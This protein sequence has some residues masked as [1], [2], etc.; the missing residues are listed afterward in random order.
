VPIQ[1][2]EVVPWG[3]SF[4][5]YR[6]MFALSPEDLAGRILGCGD[7]PASFNVEATAAGHAVVSC[8]P[9]YDFSPAEIEKRVFD[10]C[11][12]MVVQVRRDR[13]GFVWQEFRDPEHLG[14]CRL[15]VMR[16]FLANFEQGKR[17]GRYV[18]AALPNL[19]FGADRFD[20]ALVSHLLFLYSEQLDF[21][22]HWSGIQEL[23][24][25]A[26]EVRIFPLLTLERKKSPH[27]EPV[28]ARCRESGWTAEA[29]RVPYEFQRGGNEMLRIRRCANAAPR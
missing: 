23:L 28:L 11:Q 5:E 24:R 19:P 1:L 14:E 29:C 22:F 26:T 8:D 3:R 17:A 10:C 12:D 4:D 6:R 7:G 13:A 15:A 25:V 9:I 21:H 20:L 16:H 27:I 18:T 2:N